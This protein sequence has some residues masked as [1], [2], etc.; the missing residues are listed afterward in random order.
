MVLCRGPSRFVVSTSPVTCGRAGWKCLESLSIAHVCL[1]VEGDRGVK[2]TAESQEVAWGQ[3]EKNK[4]LKM[5]EKRK[6]L[7]E[8]W[9]LISSPVLLQINL[10]L[11]FPS[12][13]SVMSII[14]NHRGL[15]CPS[16]YFIKEQTEARVG[17]QVD[18]DLASGGSTGFPSLLPDFLYF[19]IVICVL[20]TM[21]TNYWRKSPL[22]NI[23]FHHSQ[24]ELD[25]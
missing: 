16:Y 17:W 12:N 1:K 23:M 22:T 6:A 13:I 21:E 4:A 10:W 14:R 5:M 20:N 9:E 19:L 24:K 11:T 3:A 7:N 18:G 2:W 15:L 8:E 25:N